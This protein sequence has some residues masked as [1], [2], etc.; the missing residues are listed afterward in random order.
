MIEGK[1]KVKLPTGRV[2]TVVMLPGNPVMPNH[3]LIDLDEPMP[4]KP[5]QQWFLAS[6]LEVIPDESES[7]VDNSPR[8]R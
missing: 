2:G 6:L 1:T 8:S 7:G 5:A 3:A 4:G